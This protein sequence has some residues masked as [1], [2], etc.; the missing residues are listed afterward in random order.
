MTALFHGCECNMKYFNANKAQKD[1]YVSL[2]DAGTLDKTANIPMYCYK[3]TD[4]VAYSYNDLVSKDVE[5]VKLMKYDTTGKHL[6]CEHFKCKNGAPII[7]SPVTT[8]VSKY[9]EVAQNSFLSALKPNPTT[10]EAALIKS[11]A[12]RNIYAAAI[13]GDSVTAPLQPKGVEEYDCPTLKDTFHT[14][15]CTA[16]HCPG[17]SG[18]GPDLSYNPSRKR[19]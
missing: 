2:A 8:P 4:G 3:D 15:G 11:I 5:L 12:D 9:T 6:G 18:P 16:T 10:G 7:G 13:Y 1:L 14:N 17:S 19:K